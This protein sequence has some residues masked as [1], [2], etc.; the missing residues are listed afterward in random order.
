MIYLILYIKCTLVIKNNYQDL[1]PCAEIFFLVLYFIFNCSAES[2]F[3]ILKRVKFYLISKSTDEK[4]SSLTV[5]TIESDLKK[6]LDYD[7]TI[8]TFLKSLKN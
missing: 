8:D 6:K 1:N 4:L 7:G 3:S 2:S 5:L